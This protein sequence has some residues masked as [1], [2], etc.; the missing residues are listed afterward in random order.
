MTRPWLSLRL[1]TKTNDQHRHSTLGVLVATVMQSTRISLQRQHDLKRLQYTT[2]T[3]AWSIDI[4]ISTNT[5]IWATCGLCWLCPFYTAI[6]PFAF[7]I[8]QLP[9]TPARLLWPH[10]YHHYCF[11]VCHFHTCFSV[12]WWILNYATYL[13]WIDTLKLDLYPRPLQW[14]LYL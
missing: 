5:F 10:E 12:R 1:E 11:Q 2:I 7:K 6:I 13:S 3:F 8:I 4:V 14:S 9:S